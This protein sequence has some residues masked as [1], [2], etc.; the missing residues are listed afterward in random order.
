[1]L[2]ELNNRGV[3][4]ILIISV[5]NPGGF[6]KVIQPAINTEIQKCDSWSVLKFTHKITSTKLLESYILYQM[7]CITV[8][9]V[10]FQTDI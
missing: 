3:R 10:Y 1:M 4:D 7:P 9:D 6:S 2:N 8:L 5:D